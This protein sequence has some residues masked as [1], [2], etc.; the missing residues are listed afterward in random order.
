MSEVLQG[1][2]WHG[3][4]KSL[5]TAINPEQR[6]ACELEGFRPHIQLETDPFLPPHVVSGFA[7]L[8]SHSW[9]SQLPT[10]EAKT[11]FHMSACQAGRVRKEGFAGCSM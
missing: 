4:W 5:K 8:G 6:R 2:E 11:G 7:G 10:R 1:P 3:F 9:F